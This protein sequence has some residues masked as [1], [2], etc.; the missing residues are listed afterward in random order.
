MAKH[1]LTDPVSKVYDIV[2]R[3]TIIL[4][5]GFIGLCTDIDRYFLR[6]FGYDLDKRLENN[7]NAFFQEVFPI[8]SGFPMEILEGLR[9][10]FNEIRDVNAHLFLNKRIRLDP[11]LAEQ[12]TSVVEPQ[13]YIVSNGELTVYG[14]IY[15]LTFMCQKYQ[16]WPFITKC[17]RSEFF[18][19]I[20]ADD[21]SEAQISLQHYLQGFCGVGKPI[22]N[23]SA[24]TDKVQMQFLNDT[25]KRSMTQVFFDLEQSILKWTFS[26][27]KVPKFSYL[28]NSNPPFSSN[29]SIKNKLIQLRNRWFHGVLLFD[30]LDTNNSEDYYSLDH[31]LSVFTDLR[32]LLAGNESYKNVVFDISSFAQSLLDF[33]CLRLVEVSYKLL[34]SRLLTQEKVDSRIKGS[35]KAFENFKK[36]PA[37]FFET[38]VSLTEKKQLSFDLAASKFADSFPR[39]T[40]TNKLSLFAIHSDI[41][42]SIGG[43]HSDFKDLFIAEIDLDEQYQNTINNWRLSDIQSVSKQW[44]SS[45]ICIKE[46]RM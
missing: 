37:A 30:Q 31:L 15:V 12:L 29:P 21:L 43:F 36:Q 23:L 18:A 19:D 9:E 25:C 27:K 6:A 10:V 39:K 35:Y 2:G 1:F 13:Q 44:Y 34:D 32:Q 28:L 3:E 46:A 24:G 42:F 17:Y 38:V 16:L 5:G 33:Y 14:M 4:K 26:S 11:L 8:L 20:I 22:Y 45:F 40:V 7:D 41:G